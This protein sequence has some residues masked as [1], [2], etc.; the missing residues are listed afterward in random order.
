MSGPACCSGSD[1]GFNGWVQGCKRWGRR[2][3]S[4]LPH[5]ADSRPV[6][7]QV[8]SVTPPSIVIVAPVIGGGSEEVKGVFQQLRSCEIFSHSSS[9]LSSCE[10]HSHSSP[11]L[12]APV[13][14]KT[15][16][17]TTCRAANLNL[18][19]ATTVATSCEKTSKKDS[20]LPLTLRS[21]EN[22]THSC[23]KFT[24]CENKNSQLLQCS[25][26]LREKPQKYSQLLDFEQL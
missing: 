25:D 5:F 7:V 2:Y 22:E 21:S 10:F 11:Q 4:L 18:T 8:V 23:S 13:T 9:I 6:F 17:S 1:A 26:E 20:Q 16:S 12:V 3:L 24:S 15:R 19:A 14:V